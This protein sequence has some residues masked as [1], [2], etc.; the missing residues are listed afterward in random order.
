M[1]EQLPVPERGRVLEAVELLDGRRQLKR[2]LGVV[3]VLAEAA[4]RWPGGTWQ[5]RGMRGANT[6]SAWVAGSTRTGLVARTYDGQQPQ[7]KR[8]CSGPELEGEADPECG[9]VVEGGGTIM[10]GRPAEI[11]SSE[12]TVPTGDRA[13]AG[14]PSAAH[15][16]H[17]DPR[18]SPPWAKRSEVPSEMF[19]RE[20]GCINPKKRELRGWIAPL[21]ETREHGL[22]CLAGDEQR[23]SSW[24]P[25]S[26]R[27]VGGRCD[28]V[29]R[30]S[31]GEEAGGSASCSTS[32][33][34]VLSQGA[35]P[36][37]GTAPPP[38][39]SRTGLPQATLDS[40]PNRGRWKAD[41]SRRGCREP[42]SLGW[43]AATL[44][45]AWDG[46]GGCRASG[47]GCWAVRGEGGDRHGTV[48]GAAGPGAAPGGPGV[49][50]PGVGWIAWSKPTGSRIWNPGASATTRRTGWSG[51]AW[52]PWGCPGSTG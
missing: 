34:L 27:E 22:R 37:L 5:L 18:G 26:H 50:G 49:A 36:S 47:N 9:N 15:A 3:A 25:L 42:R 10:E 24:R 33:G 46:K 48:T 20:A 51:S 2:M 28:T 19:R 41:W 23:R 35:S 14:R 21:G 40:K 16:G 12:G 44:P 29:Y 31:W 43:R 32:Q 39:S 13:Y 11:V 30:I 45:Q 7:E 4:C 6:A 1:L 52:R 38:N 8:T 17:E